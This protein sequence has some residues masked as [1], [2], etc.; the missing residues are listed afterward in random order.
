M[1]KGNKE[2][3]KDCTKNNKSRTKILHNI[4]ARRNHQN[5]GIV[6]EG[7]IWNTVEQY[8]GQLITADNNKSNEI[9]RR[10][11]RGRAVLG[12]YDER[13]LKSQKKEN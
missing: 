11:G 1:R 4:H 10:I 6:I 3:K 2:E 13:E 12:R 5:R 7:E 9:A 8:L